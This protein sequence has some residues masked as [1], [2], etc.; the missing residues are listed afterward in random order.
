MYVCTYL[1]EYIHVYMYTHTHVQDH[2]Y[3]AVARA[4]GD[5][6]LKKPQ[7]LVISTPEIQVVDIE[8]E[9]CF[10]VVA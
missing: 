1:Y 10:L 6:A 9:D 5:E 4:F 8:E 7:P 3:L 2:E